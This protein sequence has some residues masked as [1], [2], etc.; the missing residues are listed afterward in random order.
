V[1]HF[2]THH[3]RQASLARNPQH[4]VNHRH[5]IGQSVLS[6]R[7]RRDVATSSGLRSDA[8]SPVRHA[9]GATRNKSRSRHR[10]Q[11]SASQAAVSNRWLPNAP[12]GLHPATIVVIQQRDVLPRA[13]SSLV[14]QRRRENRD[15]AGPAG[16]R[17][18]IFS[19]YK[20]ARHPGSSKFGVPFV[21]SA[22]A[23]VR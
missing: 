7:N 5:H 19:S 4:R 12:N 3:N 9:T 16:G 23:A 22:L 21:K 17:V 18:S 20:I 13:V 2:A 6:A 14:E 1:Q 11:H 10:V 8:G 15:N